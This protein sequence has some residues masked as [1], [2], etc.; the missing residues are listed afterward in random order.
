MQTRWRD[1][2]PLDVRG[3]QWIL[4]GGLIMLLYRGVTPQWG[5]ELW[6]DPNYSHGLLIPFIS[7]YLFR[8]RLQALS[9]A[10]TTRQSSWAGLPIVIVAL[11]MLIVGY[12][13]AEFFTKRISLIVLL[14]GSLCLL[15][16]WR[17]AKAVSF[18]VGLLFFAVPLPYILYNSVA[19]PLKLLASKIAVRLIALSGMPVFL[20]GNVISLPHTTLEVVDACSG[21]RSLMTLITLAFLLAYFHHKQIWKRLLVLIMAVPVAVMANAVRVATTG[22]LTQY[23]Q[24]WGHGTLHDF[25][26]WLVF[27]ASFAGLGLCSYLLKS[28]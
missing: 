14:F 12:I 28:K 5:M 13:G 25:Q 2:I 23:S 8:E 4:L 10:N 20:E 26:G 1:F 24:A 19:F 27:V 6:N 21:I 22:Y 15:E 9:E 18:P 16:G 3:S 11:V 7:V 17:Y